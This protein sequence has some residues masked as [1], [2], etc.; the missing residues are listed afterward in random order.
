M[1]WIS[2]SEFMDTLS[3]NFQAGGPLYVGDFYFAFS[4]ALLLTSFIAR[5]ITP[6]GHALAFFLGH[7]NQTPHRQP[8]WEHATDLQIRKQRLLDGDSQVQ[9]KQWPLRWL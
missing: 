8:A 4:Q 2:F 6:L 9:R 1:M 3:V 7:G 5:H